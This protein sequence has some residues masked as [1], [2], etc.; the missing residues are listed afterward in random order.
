[1][2]HRLN[3]YAHIAEALLAVGQGLTNSTD[4]FPLGADIWSRIAAR[5]PEMSGAERYHPDLLAAMQCMAKAAQ[6]INYVCRQS[7]EGTE[8]GHLVNTILV[9]GEL[10]E[11]IHPPEPDWPANVITVDFQSRCR[12]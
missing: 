3:P 11:A 8:I 1:M 2:N 4:T 6:H 9:L 7:E 10:C 5:E 12:A